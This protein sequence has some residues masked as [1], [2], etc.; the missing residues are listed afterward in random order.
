MASSMVHGM[1]GKPA[2][3]NEDAYPLWKQKFDPESG[4]QMIEEDLFAGES[5]VT[6]MMGVILVG[7]TM[8]VISVILSVLIAL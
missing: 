8:A 4:R 1:M 7:V 6:E 2:Q 5:V 3:F